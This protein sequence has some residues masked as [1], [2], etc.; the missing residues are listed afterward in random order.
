MNIATE[1]LKSSLSKEGSF[2]KTEEFINWLDIRKQAVN[3][4]IEKI[5]FSELVNW[6]FDATSTDL[7]HDSGKFFSIEGIKVTTNW[8]QNMQWSQPIIN[9][10]EIGFLGII[11]K[12]FNGIL[13]FLMQAKI[14]PG[15][16]NYV[17]LSPT[18]QATKSNY[19][20]VH[21]G[22]PPTYLKYFLD[23]TGNKKILLDQLQSEQ[24]ARFLRKRNRNIIIEIEEEIKVYDDFC[25]LTLGQIHQLLLHDNLVNMDSRT[26]ISGIPFGGYNAEI[27]NLFDFITP[28]Y[29]SDNEYAK[30]MLISAIENENHLNS[31]EEILSWFTHLKSFYE[32]KVEKIP[33]QKIEKWCFTDEEIHHE[34]NKYFK[35][36]PVRAEIANREVKSWTQPLVESVQQGIIAFIIKKIDNVYH[37]LVQAKL[38]PGNLDVLEMAPT[39]Q[40]LTGNY[41]DGFSEYVVP[42]L[43]Y[44]MQSKGSELEKYS[45]FQSEEGGR[46]FREQNQ[47]IIVEADESEQFI[48]LP[49]NFIWMTLNQMKTF[50][51]YNNYLNIQARSLM[52]AIGFI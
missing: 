34:D 14:E 9:Q 32:L 19:T 41:R 22:N 44:I 45:T 48:N 25:W 49:D 30:G 37:F 35:V 31:N 12:K 17:Q 52:S 7:I 6:G 1:F 23:R 29:S 38:E 39:V 3:V 2:I 47:N 46:F 20:Q 18:L 4:N 51:Q 40:C 5:K 26:V 8:G 15:N 13:H 33:L 42:Y 27:I 16:I 10:D 43:D 21:K 28:L 24:G 36:I 11:T 50:V